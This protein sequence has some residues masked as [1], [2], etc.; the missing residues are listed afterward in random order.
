MPARMD[1]SQIPDSPN[2][3]FESSLWS[4]SILHIAGLDEAGRGAWAGPVVAAAVVLPNDPSIVEALFGVRDSK[5]LSPEKRTLLSPRIKNIAL[6]WGVG[7]SDPLEIDHFGIVPATRIAM[8]RALQDLKISPDHLLL[9]A[10]FLPENPT[11]QTALIKGDQRSLT[12]A[13]ASILAKTARDD[14]ML[15]MHI[16][17]PEY[18]FD[19]HKGYGTKIH[20]NAL[21]KNGKTPIH[22][23]SFKPLRNIS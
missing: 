3:H 21:L 2:L 11:P 10:L 20:Q 18:G 5:Q 19:R 7:F 14:W 12:I 13:A 4:D 9:D 8:Q 16:E 6:A 17:H 23:L 15:D 22:R 1:S